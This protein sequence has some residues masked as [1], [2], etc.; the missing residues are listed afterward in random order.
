MR[1]LSLL[2][3]LSVL[4]FACTQK[5]PSSPESQPK[6]EVP[7][8]PPAG[9]S[10]QKTVP[11]TADVVAAKVEVDAKGTTRVTAPQDV[12]PDPVAPADVVAPPADA[13][14]AVEVP[15]IPIA[16]VEEAVK[17]SFEIPTDPD[18][19]FPHMAIEEIQKRQRRFAPALLSYDEE[20]LSEE[21]KAVLK[22]LIHACRI[23]DDIFWKQASHDGLKWRDLLGKATTVEGRTLFRFLLTNYGAFD[24]LGGNEP[25]LGEASKPKG[26]AY[27]PADMTKEEFE[28]HLQENP[29]DEAAFKSNFTIIVRKDGKLAS[30]PYSEAYAN[31]LKAMADLMKQAARK[32]T[33]ASLA[34]YLRSR[35]DA[36][37]SN[38]YF[39]SDVDWMD[40]DSKIELTIGPYEV[41]EDELL[42]YKAAF[43]CFLTIRDEEASRKLAVYESWLD[44]M[45]KNLPIAEDRKNF[46]RGKSSPMVVVDILLT[47]GD[48]R[49]G[50]QTIAFNLPNDERV[51]EQKGSKKVMLHNIM[52][53]KF[54]KILMRIARL[55]LADGLMP[56]VHFD[57]FFAHTLVHEI[58][59]G[60]G[61]GN[62]TV[63]GKKTTVNLALKELYPHLEEAKADTLGLYNAFYLI[64]QGVL[65][66]PKLD[67]NGKVDGKTMLSKEEA[68][69]A[70]IVTFLAGIFRSTR[71]GTHEA[72]GKG[73]LVIFNYLMA[74]KAVSF[75]QDGKLTYDEALFAPAIQS[76]A[77]DILNIQAEGSYDGCKLFLETY[78]EKVGEP[79]QMALQTLAA[80]P[81]DIDPLFKLPTP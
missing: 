11:E 12:K 64:D 42:G 21:E 26:A 71:F 74:K 43:E 77:A 36:F 28:K 81:V 33:N 25:F 5:A 23:A 76:L 72:H 6:T 27:Y 22:P 46:Q 32:T 37:L 24:R 10:A 1:A 48:T 35:A 59:H 56:H 50:V 14:L 2:F 49:A 19:P 31:D 63:D 7:G 61:P 40:L 66:I 30:V 78:G 44:K 8:A 20:G 68:K 79:M 45:E 67:A 16:P 29:A 51:R 60:L 54:E 13:K 69:K 55:V 58:S 62:I 18:A 70:A 9:E 15:A 53:A 47:A 65:E 34:R 41:Y 3:V 80:L 4:A 75:N 38:D 39:A 73:N 17:K 57:A 52:R